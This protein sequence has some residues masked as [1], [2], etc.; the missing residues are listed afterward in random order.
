MLMFGR[1]QHNKNVKKNVRENIKDKKPFI[2]RNELVG[3]D[4]NGE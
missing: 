4:N 3:R 1:N 2:Q